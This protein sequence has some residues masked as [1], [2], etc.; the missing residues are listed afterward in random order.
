MWNPAIIGL[1]VVEKISLLVACSVFLWWKFLRSL[2]VELFASETCCSH[3]SVCLICSFP[4][5]TDT[6]CFTPVYVH[7][8]LQYA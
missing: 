6:G 4:V 7:V 3:D 1:L 2:R 5:E 8:G